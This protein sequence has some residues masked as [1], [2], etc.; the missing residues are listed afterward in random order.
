MTALL[1]ILL[2]YSAFVSFVAG[3][4]WR[5]RRDRFRSYITGPHAD[6]AQRIGLTAFRIGIGLLL[7]ARVAEALTAGPHTH[8]RGAIHVVLTVVELVAIPLAAVGAGLLLIP[9]MINAERVITP[10]DRITLPALIACMLSAVLIEFDPNST[11]SEYRTAETLFVWFRSLCAFRPDADAMAHAP[12][13][14]QARGLSLLLLIS[15]WPYTRL[16]GTFAGPIVALVRRRTM[17]AG[18]LPSTAPTA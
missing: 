12:F 15:I 9:H 14:Y 17:R 16:A 5:Y 13:I 4:V 18:A 6:R 3:H 7:T 11:D 2:P 10:L 8:P 1:W